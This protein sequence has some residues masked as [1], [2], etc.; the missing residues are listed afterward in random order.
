MKRAQAAI[1]LLGRSKLVSP[2]IFL[3]SLI[4]AITLHFS[5]SSVSSG[6]SVFERAGLVLVAHSLMFNVIYVLR[7]YAF[8]PRGR[9]W[10]LLGLFAIVVTAAIFR[11]IVMQFLIAEFQIASFNDLQYKVLMSLQ[12]MTV[13]IMTA[14]FF[15]E[16]LHEWSDRTSEL[17]TDNLRL[18][19]L[20]SNS[21]R[22]IEETHDR[23]ISTVTG[24]LYRFLHDLE[25]VSPEKLLDS[26]RS[27]VA[28]IVRPLSREYEELEAKVPQPR[29]VTAKVSIFKAIAQI[30]Y[31]S[32]ID[33]FVVP[34]GLVFISFPFFILYFGASKVLLAILCFFALS[35]V[36]Q[37]PIRWGFNKLAPKSGVIS[38]AVLI[39]GAVIRALV[40]SWAFHLFFNNIPRGQNWTFWLIL[41]FGLIFASLFAVAKSLNRQLELVERDLGQIQIRLNW[42]VARSVEVQRQQSQAL[43]IA[44]H[45]PVQTAV[46]AGIIRLERAL[47]N[48]PISTELIEEVKQLIW[49]SLDRLS[50]D[51]EVPNLD[52][53][54]C[55]V[56]DTWV[57]V[58]RIDFGFAPKAAEDLSHDKVAT[59][60]LADILPELIF[61]AIKH[62]GSTWVKVQISAA[63]GNSIGFSMASDGSPYEASEKK[64]LGLKY[65]EDAALSISHSN[66]L[67]NNLVEIVLPYLDNSFAPPSP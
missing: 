15:T 67:G 33:I 59:R 39:L 13:V 29:P 50:E 34:A 8:P 52:S 54:C 5:D 49:A 9:S 4:W 28:E 36:V 55:D 66:G 22:Q 62:S 17:E 61:N 56:Q 35:S 1:R 10:E 38:W 37:F 63:A 48:G 53:V 40:G 25:K 51:K 65:L 26:L 2:G 12:N 58:C 57:D 24:Q 7:R 45:G 14:A 64:G 19:A 44:I 42:E 31:V 60:L 6:A 46:G 32:P 20:L 23:L 27:G 30:G 16:A 43:S 47:K 41:I 18:Q 3:S 21:T 11:G